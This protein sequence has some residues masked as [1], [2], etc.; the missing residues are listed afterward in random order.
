MSIFDS[1]ATV[2]DAAIRRVFGDA[3][4]VTVGD[5]V[6]VLDAIPT[7]RGESEGGILPLSDAR[8]VF[9]FDAAEFEATGAGHG[10]LIEWAGSPYRIIDAQADLFGAVSVSVTPAGVN[11]PA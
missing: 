4:T 9:H 1:Y 5:D 8:R 10:H 11:V 7:E 3:V 2:A 6:F